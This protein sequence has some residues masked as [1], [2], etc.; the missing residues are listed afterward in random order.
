MSEW[1]YLWFIDCR[2][3]TCEYQHLLNLSLSLSYVHEHITLA[4]L[5]CD[6]VLFS[7]IFFSSFIFGFFLFLHSSVWERKWGCNGFFA[8]Y[9]LLWNILAGTTP[10]RHFRSHALNLLKSIFAPFVFTNRRRCWAFFERSVQNSL[11]ASIYMSRESRTN[12]S[13]GELQS[14]RFRRTHRNVS[15]FDHHSIVAMDPPMNHPWPMWRRLVSVDIADSFG[16]LES[17]ALMCSLSSIHRHNHLDR[18]FRQPACW[19]N[20]ARTNNRHPSNG[21]VIAGTVLLQRFG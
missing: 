9:L 1:M 4:K 5:L 11:A 3:N 19:P 15:L 6:L 7:Y 2:I 8:N 12:H 13:K 18:I 21:I 10:P 20:A 14:N 17:V 16:N